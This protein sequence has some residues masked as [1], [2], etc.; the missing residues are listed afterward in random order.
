MVTRRYKRV[1]ADNR[2][3]RYINLNTFRVDQT[4]FANDVNKLAKKIALQ[5]ETSPILL[6]DSLNEILYV[7]LYDGFV[8]SNYK[9]SRVAIVR[10]IGRHRKIKTLADIRSR[11]QQKV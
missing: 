3:F 2:I 9:N 5:R 11:F 4:Y 8:V 6:W 7:Y 10:P 1:Q